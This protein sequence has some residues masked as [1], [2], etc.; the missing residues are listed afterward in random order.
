[1]KLLYTNILPLGTSEKQETIFEAVDIAGQAT[2]V[3][4]E[5]LSVI[6]NIQNYMFELPRIII[7]I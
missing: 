4:M 7:P 3:M 5:R 2:I 6:R 1:M